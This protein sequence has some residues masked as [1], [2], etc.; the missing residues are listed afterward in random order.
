MKI[1]RKIRD[2]YKRTIILFGIIKIHYT[3]KKHHQHDV[4]Y[5]FGTCG[6]GVVFCGGQSI[7][8]PKNVFIGNNVLLGY[9]LCICAIGKVIIGNNVSFGPSVTIWSANHNYFNPTQL[10]YDDDVIKKVVTIEDNVWIGAHAKI[11]P[12]VTIH[13]GAVV[14][15]GAVVTKD[16]PKCAVV[17]GNPAV[18]LKYRDKNTYKKLVKGKKF[19]NFSKESVQ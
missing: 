19:H 11:C 7:D 15:M 16:V 10:P 8:F 9:G 12:G 4:K 17:G 1:F 14:G 6:N 3:K 13:E 2:G 18:V 5:D